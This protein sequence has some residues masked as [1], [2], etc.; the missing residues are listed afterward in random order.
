MAA[1]HG[2]QLKIEGRAALTHFSLDYGPQ[3]QALRTLLTQEMLD[4]GCLATAV[5]Y[6]T[7]THA[8]QIIDEY[9]IAFDEVCGI[10]SDAVKQNNI[11]QRLHGPVANT[12]SP[13]PISP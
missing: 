2:L 5:F 7:Y 4:R 6:V 9:L 1:K 12:T 13:A 8:S 11:D 3:G 10:L